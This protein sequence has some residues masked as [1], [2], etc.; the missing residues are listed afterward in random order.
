MV[1]TSSDWD[2]QSQIHGLKYQIGKSQ[3]TS[4]K[5]FFD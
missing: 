2:I 3:K 5:N 4:Q 1:V